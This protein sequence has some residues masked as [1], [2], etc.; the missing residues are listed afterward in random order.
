MVVD[1][2]PKG[3]CPPGPLKGPLPIAGRPRNRGQH[4]V[5]LGEMTDPPFRFPIAVGKGLCA[6]D[7]DWQ[8]PTPRSGRPWRHRARPVP[9]HR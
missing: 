8:T 1:I 7:R 9:L 6:S 3:D 5:S 2:T 4:E